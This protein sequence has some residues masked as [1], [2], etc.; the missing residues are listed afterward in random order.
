MQKPL[1]INTLS[2]Q[3]LILKQIIY[4][5]E[6][7]RLEISHELHENI[8]Q[9]L[10]AVKLHIGLAKTNNTKEAFHYLEEALDILQDALAAV[11]SLASSISPMVL[12]ALGFKALIADLLQLLEEQGEIKCRV[13]IDPDIISATPLGIQ[14]IFYQIAQLRIISFLQSPSITEVSIGIH[15]KGDKVQML[16]AND[17][18]YEKLN[19][20]NSKGFLTMK[21]KIEAF[22]GSFTIKM[23]AGKPGS[24][25]EVVL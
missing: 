16:I 21:D 13:N 10:V 22:D 12:K 24:L 19:H 15:Q 6:N 20:L 9:L 23:Q 1:Q 11:K 4:N 7:E 25:L 8:A 17:G 5:D 14:N 3:L 2:H 18:M